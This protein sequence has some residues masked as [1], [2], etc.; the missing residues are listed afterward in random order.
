LAEGSSVR[1]HPP[2]AGPDSSWDAC[3]ADQPWRFL[4][5]LLSLQ[6]PATPKARRALWFSQK[7]IHCCML[8][9]DAT[10]L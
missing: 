1:F 9:G 4:Q 5:Q 10:I 2:E 6:P 8:I 7:E 3:G